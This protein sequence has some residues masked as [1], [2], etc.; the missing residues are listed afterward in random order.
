LYGEGL[1]F[2]GSPCQVRDMLTAMHRLSD[3]HKGFL[4]MWVTE[5]I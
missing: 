1:Y 4:E 5:V 3:P 2:I